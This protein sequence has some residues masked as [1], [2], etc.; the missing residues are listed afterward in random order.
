[1]EDPCSS[2]RGVLSRPHL[3]TDLALSWRPQAA[4]KVS[5][6]WINLLPCLLSR[7]LCF[8]PCFVQPST[9]CLL[10]ELPSKC[11]KCRKCNF[12]QV[13]CLPCAFVNPHDPL[14][15]APLATWPYY[16]RVCVVLAEWRGVLPDSL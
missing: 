16:K 4:C 11:E 7:L 8:L 10:Q 14:P 15:R 5:G 13:K 9:S 12:L 1:V 6:G 3:W 2:A